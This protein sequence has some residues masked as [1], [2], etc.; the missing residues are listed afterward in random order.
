MNMK[1]LSFILIAFLA[2]MFGKAAWVDAEN[3]TSSNEVLVTLSDSVDL[4][5]GEVIEVADVNPEF[6]GGQ[7]AL[8]QF[9]GNNL[10]YPESAQ[11]AGIEGRVLVTFIVGADGV[12]RNP[13]VY[14]SVDEALDKEALRVIAL[15]PAWKPGT[16][17]EK[18]VNVKFTIPVTFR[19]QNNDGAKKPNGQMPPRM[20]GGPMGGFMGG[21]RTTAVFGVYKKTKNMRG[22][23]EYMFGVKDKM[24][25]GYKVTVGYNVKTQNE[26]LQQ[27]IA[28]RVFG[29]RDNFEAAVKAFR[30]TFEEIKIEEAK[31][32]IVESETE[33]CSQPN[34]VVG[35]EYRS[36]AN[37]TN[38]QKLSNAEYFL[39]DTKTNKVVTLE[40]LITPKLND[41]L[42]SKGVET[43]KSTNIAIKDQS[44]IAVTSLQVITM[45]G[46]K[47]KDNLSDYALETLGLTR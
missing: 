34:G 24:H 21:P 30:K 44:F 19:L 18:P 46:V 13:K 14:K 39:F 3:R 25:Q 23:D 29:V 37:T 42:K 6:P 47:L 12:V 26:T 17:K 9:L 11:K 40:D 20:G 31:K 36:L 38:L 45:D 15:M 33:Y 43:D 22:F 8:M 32:S 41:Y 27:E 7:E 16:V 2:A 35:I 10:Q 1:R 4:P 5:D 28:E